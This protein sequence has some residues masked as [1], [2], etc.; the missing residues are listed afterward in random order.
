MLC[1]YYELVDSDEKW[2]YILG[3]N[4]E[5]KNKNVKKYKVQLKLDWCFTGVAPYK[6]AIAK[7]AKKIQIAAD[8]R[9]VLCKVQYK[10]DWCFAGKVPVI[11]YK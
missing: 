7:D 2:K 5:Y 8:I 9:L 11:Q 6:T 3:R 4:T 10:L 1:R